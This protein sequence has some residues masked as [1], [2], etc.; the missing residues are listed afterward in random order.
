M[1][2]WLLS[3]SPPIR[4]PLFGYPPPVILQLRRDESEVLSLSA[5]LQVVGRCGL[6]AGARREV[7]EAVVGEDEEGGLEVRKGARGGCGRDR[8]L[9][10]VNACPKE[11]NS[12]AV[13]WLWFLSA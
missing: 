7:E 2:C 8:V 9:K 12:N 4:P 5:R 13:V 10:S 6:T 3:S 1:R 11:P